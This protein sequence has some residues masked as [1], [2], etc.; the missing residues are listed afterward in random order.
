MRVL[1]YFLASVLLKDKTIFL[2]ISNSIPYVNAA[3]W[4]TSV[5]VQ[6]RSKYSLALLMGDSS[7]SSPSNSKLSSPLAEGILR[8]KGMK[9]ETSA[10]C[11]RVTFEGSH[12]HP[13]W[14]FHEDFSRHTYPE[15]G[16]QLPRSVSS[17]LRS[18]VVHHVRV[19]YADVVC[20]CERAK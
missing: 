18:H 1:T 8:M 13:E 14:N 15:E 4:G 9:I 12:R 11:C 19:V 16:S 2:T 20:V 7:C 3:S 10:S 6:S 5:L 17:P